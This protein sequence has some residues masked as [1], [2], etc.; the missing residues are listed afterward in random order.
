M[1]VLVIVDPQDRSKKYPIWDQKALDF[2][3]AE[4]YN[5][6]CTFVIVG[7]ILSHVMFGTF[8]LEQ[9]SPDK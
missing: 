5:L 1:S 6:F 3:L 8:F 9:I 4:R 7:R 2:T